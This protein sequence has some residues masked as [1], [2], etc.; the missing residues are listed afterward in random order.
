MNPSVKI[1][2][3]PIKRIAK[4]KLVAGPAR[5]IFPFLSFP[6]CPAIITAPGAANTIPKKEVSTA[7]KSIKLS[8]LN[9]AKQPYLWATILCPISCNRK[10][11]PTVTAESITFAMK[12]VPRTPPERTIAN[13]IEIINQAF[14]RSLNSILENLI[15][16]IF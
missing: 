5:E 15:L 4:T 3:K 9:S 10:P 12:N 13:A 7:T 14:A 1:N 6:T 11:T 2:A 8:A 16:I